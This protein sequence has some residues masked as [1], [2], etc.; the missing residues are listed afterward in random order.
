MHCALG[1]FQLSQDNFSGVEIIFQIGLI[2]G[3]LCWLES[4]H[5]AAKSSSSRTEAH[6]AAVVS[7][8]LLLLLLKAAQLSS[9]FGRCCLQSTTKAQQ[10]KYK[11]QSA[12]ML[13]SIDQCN[14]YCIVLHGAPQQKAFSQLPVQ[15][16]RS[17]I[18]ERRQ[19]EMRGAKI[20][21]GSRVGAGGA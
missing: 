4:L 7:W 18:L 3:L 5:V 1:C 14:A 12:Q 2:L 21:W 10:A 16:G 8:M 11:C 9:T 20:L 13:W 6:I 15:T 17:W 19:C